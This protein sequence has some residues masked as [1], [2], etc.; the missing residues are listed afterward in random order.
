[1]LHMRMAAENVRSNWVKSHVTNGRCSA[2]ESGRSDANCPGVLGRVQAPLAAL[3]ADAALTRPARSQNPQLSE[4]R[5]RL[6]PRW[7]HGEES[8]HTATCLAIQKGEHVAL[9]TELDV[10]DNSPMVRPR[11]ANHTN[12]DRFDL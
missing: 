12:R 2:V 9:E 8:T 10:S 1:M 11:Q 4:R 7:H 3:A 6:T 5:R